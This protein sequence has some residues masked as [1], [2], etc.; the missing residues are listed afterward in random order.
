MQLTYEQLRAAVGGALIVRE[1]TEGEVEL[2]RF[3]EEQQRF[4]RDH[5]ALEIFYLETFAAS[6]ITLELETD[7]DYLSL[8][9][10]TK[11]AATRAF[12]F[13]DVKVDGVLTAH[14]GHRDIE[15]AYAT[16]RVALPEGTHRVCIYFP[17]YASVA[18]RAL[19]LSDGATFAPV[20]RPL[21]LL[22]YGDSITQGLLAEHP[23]CIYATGLA[24]A[25][26]A[27]V[28]NQGIG[29]ERFVPAL[30]EFDIDFA[31]DL[32]TVAFG[33]NDWRRLPRE[34]VVAN[35]HAFYEKL[36]RRYP[37]T[38]IFAITPLWR[39]DHALE[40][41][42]GD[43]EDVRV[44]IREAAAENAA[45]VIEGD[46]LVPH[47]REAFGDERLHPNDLGFN[48]YTS[49]L[50]SQMRPYLEKETL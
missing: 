12:Y 36:R 29:G 46:G 50:L 27:E 13:I 43:F 5:G 2:R 31:P 9:Y 41:D 26:G 10:H 42:F 19:E 21:K 16:A 48:C 25:L 34:T 45:I 40:T 6:G 17:C 37:S 32:I 14:I 11:R 7:S 38:K 30:L 24:D 22:A 15:E 39:A 4:Y 18:I 28:L 8:S 23:S 3:N 49:A 44:L 47:V 35:A 20:K 1:N 33:T